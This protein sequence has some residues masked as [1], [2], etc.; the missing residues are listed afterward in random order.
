MG[1]VQALWRCPGN[2]GKVQALE[3][4]PGVVGEVQALDETSRHCERS[5][6]FVG[7]S[8]RCGE[9]QA[10]CERSWRW[11][12]PGAGETLRSVPA[13]GL[14]EES[15]RCGRSPGVVGEVQ[16]LFGRPGKLS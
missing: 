16:A 3:G 11:R 10:L 4:S 13:A 5:Q 15:M 2:V 6:G 7:K 8:R 12:R 14:V 9:V 1:E